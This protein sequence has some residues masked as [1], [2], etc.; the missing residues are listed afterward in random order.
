MK[1]HTL[2]SWDLNTGTSEWVL[3][4]W[5]ALGKVAILFKGF[6]YL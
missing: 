1:P 3:I 2:G 5:R 6:L 4:P